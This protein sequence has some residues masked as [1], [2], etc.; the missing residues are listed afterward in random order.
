MR[1]DADA[2]ALRDVASPRLRPTVLDVT[3]E[4]HIQAAAAVVRDVTG[5][6]GL[7]AIVNIAGAT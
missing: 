7:A 3:R 4:D 5:P 1:R 6:L 2:Q